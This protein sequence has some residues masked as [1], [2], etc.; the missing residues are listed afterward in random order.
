[1]EDVV[2]RMRADIKVKIEGKE[3][4]RVTYVSDAAKTAQ[5]ATDRLASLYIEENLRDQENVAQ[6]T[7]QFLES[8]LEDA[9]R[10]LA[11]HEKK[12]E[13]YK[14]RHNGQLPSQLQANLQSIQNA[15][16]QLQSVSESTNRARERRILI[17]RQ[18]AD[19]QA[20]P[21]LMRPL[22]GTASPSEPAALSTAQ[23]LESAEARLVLYKQ[24]YT[25]DHPDVRALERS[26][27]ELR[28]K[29][30]DEAKRAP[31][32]S[33]KALTPL[34]ATR[35]R[36]INELQAQLEAID[37]QIRSNTEEE[38]RLKNTILDYQSKVNAVPARESELVELM[39]DY[40]TVS[41]S[42]SSLLKRREDSKLVEDLVHRQ[43][44]EQFKVL[45]AASLPQK[46]YNR[47]QRQVVLGAGPVAGLLLG[48]AL[49][50]LVEYRDSSF[51]TEGEVSRL[52][53]LPVLALVPTLASEL[54][55]AKL[56]RRQWLMDICG[57]AAVVVTVAA[58][59]FWRL[60]P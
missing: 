22:D 57:S 54:D 53:S 45:D 37:L 16:L 31:A 55:R 3:S 34:E 42:Y 5:M 50:G 7:N 8:Q 4:F 25:P 26:I 60:Q 27:V 12:L 49:I 56:R 58:L 46:P 40:A 20:T 13:E 48:L 33:Q 23:Q 41:E 29:L 39:R 21:A 44:G 10:R 2:Q 28:Q 43:I 15:Q 36:Q 1:M 59:V 19:A 18:L 52:L 47:L 51:K 6:N 32:S 38:R 30:E 11:E 9:K 17:D 35:H 14:S 24:R